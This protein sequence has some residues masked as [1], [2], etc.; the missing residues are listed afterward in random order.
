MAVRARPRL[1]R[2]RR[3][4]LTLLALLAILLALLALLALAPPNLGALRSQADPVADYAAAVARVSAL[5]AEEAVLINPECATRLLTHGQ[6]TARVI[7]FVHGYT[8]CPQQ[9]ADLGQ[10]FYDLGDN[11][12]ILRMPHH[13]LA[14]RLTDDLTNFTA[15]EMAGVADLAVDLAVG[16]G[17]HVTFVGLSGG[18]TVAG[19][20]AQQRPEVDQAVL[21]APG[22]SLKAIP[23]PATQLFV[24]AVLRLPDSFS[25]WDPR[26]PNPPPGGPMDHAYPRFS[27]HG[28]A[29]QLRLGLAVRAL[30]RRA[31]PAAG[32]ILLITNAADIAVNNTVAAQV[33]ADW[34]A[35]GATVGSYEFPAELRLGHDLIDPGQGDQ[36]V[37]VVYPQLVALINQ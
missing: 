30:A 32:R 18:G 23:D 21:I 37:A 11:V 22:F 7:T 2:W 12:L 20:A 29:Q 3:L 25:W 27:L 19:W 36:Q 1:R 28:L 35:H 5:Q 34:Q 26:N 24:N 8:N 16:L 13:G 31:A 17:D 6:R 10:Q 33:L 15:E 4:G 9:F 14:D